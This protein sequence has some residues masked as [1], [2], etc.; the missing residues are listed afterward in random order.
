M[1]ERM[2]LL[3]EDLKHLFDDRGIDSSLYDDKVDFE[4]PITRWR[5]IGG[6]KFNIAM[7][8]KVFNPTFILHDMRQTGEY[9]LTTRWTMTMPFTLASKLPFTGWWNPSLVFTGVSVMGVNP[10]TGLFNKHLDLWDALEKQSYFSLEAFAH[11][12][13]QMGNIKRAPPLEA[14][15]HV[16]LR[17]RKEYEIRRYEPYVTIQTQIA[18]TSSTGD[19]MNPKGAGRKAFARVVPYFMGK[20]SRAEQLQMTVPAYSDPRGNLEVYLGSQYKDPGSAPEPNS[21]DL[22]LQQRPG[23]FYAVVQFSGIVDEQRAV[24]IQAQLRQHL[25][26]DGLAAASDEWILARYNDPQKVKPQFRLNEIMV[27]V[28]DFKLW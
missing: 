26:R 27:P 7:L 28:K 14:P 24:D 6:Y 2:D 18:G 5:S 13:S 20:N 3:R 12:L 15:Q 25:Q 16:V 17:K 8:R 9:E 22:K 19:E 4:D 10:E 21:Q 1:Q 23:G 11:V